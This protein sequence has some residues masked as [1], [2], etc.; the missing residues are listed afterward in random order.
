VPPELRADASAAAWLGE[1]ER[2]AR[3]LLQQIDN[4]AGVLR[5]VATC[6]VR[7][8]A[9]FFDRGPAGQA[10]LTRTEVADELGLHPSTVSRAVA[11][12]TLRCPNGKVIG[13]AS[14]FGG[15]VAIKAAIA[16]IAGRQRMSDSQLRAELAAQGFHLARRTVAKYRAELGIAPHG[17][18]GRQG[19]QGRRRT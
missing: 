11:G 13:L 15:D 17:R 18:Q 3:A 8:Q 2:A 16:D 10:L 4:R 14:L 5:R 1:H 6:V 19:R 12:K 7:R 9:G